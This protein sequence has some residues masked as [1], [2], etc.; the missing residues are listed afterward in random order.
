[1]EGRL[2]SNPRPVLAF[3]YCRCLRLA[4][5]VHVCTYTCPCV[6]PGPRFTKVFS[7]AIQI[8]WKF[9]FA[10][11]LILIQWL[12]QNFVHNSCAVVACAK[13]CCDLMANNRITA[14][15]MF[16]W[17]WILGK[18]LSVKRAPELVSA[19]TCHLFKPGSPNLDQRCKTPWLRSLLF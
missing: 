11:T 10:L 9:R 15:Q 18:K 19:I 14:R 6:N 17:I 16:H 1:M 2:T 4:V 12:L 13:I 5:C 3:R 7:I 8:R